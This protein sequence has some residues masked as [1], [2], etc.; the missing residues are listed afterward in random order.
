MIQ[1]CCLTQLLHS[2]SL[3]VCTV[4]ALFYC[5]F[6]GLKSIQARVVHHDW[7]KQCILQKLGA[8]LRVWGD[9]S[10]SVVKNSLL[11]S[12]SSLDIIQ[13]YFGSKAALNVCFFCQDNKRIH[14]WRQTLLD[15][16]QVFFFLLW[17]PTKKKVY[18]KIMIYCIFK[19][20]T[21]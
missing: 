15:L 10:S 16:L 17:T 13:P 12:T 20:C 9:C 1:H 14:M 6:F 7:R 21:E 3:H 18:M 5:T 19:N 8:I 11:K 2:D 4:T